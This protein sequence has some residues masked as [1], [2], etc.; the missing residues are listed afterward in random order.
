[1]KKW[2]AEPEA[3]T[4]IR[5]SS[6]TKHLLNQADVFFSEEERKQRNKRKE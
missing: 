6:S 1:M 5:K 2:I 4:E 3:E